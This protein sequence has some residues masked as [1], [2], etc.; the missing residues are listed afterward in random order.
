VATGTTATLDLTL[1]NTGN[2]DLTGILVGTYPAGFTEQRTTCTG[3]L[4]ES[5]TCTITVAFTPTDLIQYDGTLSI[6][7]DLVAVTNSPVALSGSGQAPEGAVAFT[8]ASLGTLNVAGEELDFGD[9]SGSRNFSTVTLTVSG[10]PVTFG[11]VTVSGA[12]FSE[13]FAG[14]TRCQ[15]QT[16]AAG[17]TCTVIVRFRPRNGTVERVGSLTVNHNGTGGSDTLVLLGQ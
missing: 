2:A 15:N 9:L 17:D 6:T 1:S 11:A 3:P 13:P 10:D 12:R 7:A 16:I 14:P 5:A 8:S 4:A